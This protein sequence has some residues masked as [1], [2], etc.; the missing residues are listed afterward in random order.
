MKS[1]YIVRLAFF[2][3]LLLQAG[4][5]DA[6]GLIVYRKNGQP[7]K[8]P[9]AELDSI[10]TDCP[11]ADPLN[12]QTFKIKDVSFN[13][14]AVEGGTFMM[15]SEFG[16][17]DERPVHQVTLDTYYIGE[18]EVTNELW[19][20]VMGYTYYSDF[21]K[22]GKVAS[23]VP[24][25][26]KCQLFIK[27]LNEITGATFRLPTEAEWEFAARGGNRSMGYIY[28]GSNDCDEVAWYF[29]GDAHQV[30]TKKANELGLYDMSGNSMEWCQDMYGAYPSGP[31]TNPLCNVGDIHVL[32]GGYYF[33]KDVKDMRVT[34]RWPY[35][36]EGNYW[37]KGLRLVM[38]IPK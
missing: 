9:Y 27:S 18:T 20:A 28:S 15:G 17:S 37:F 32:R 36:S 35:G 33:T 6:Q 19:F 1:N 10:T 16:E 26:E 2:A 38:S 3:I 30:G 14:I 5:A 23:S 29:S 4:G 22:D 34:R 24:T 31:I 25:W 7:I 12:R 13:M 8:I 11:P 21:Q